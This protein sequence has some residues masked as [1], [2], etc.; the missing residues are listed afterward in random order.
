MKLP[1]HNAAPQRTLR[2]PQSTPVPQLGSSSISALYRAAR[3]GGDFY[4]FLVTDSRRLVFLLLDVAGK[5]EEALDIAA[6]VQ[7]RMHPMA[8]ELLRADDVNEADALP[9]LLIELNRVIIQAAGGVRCAPAFLGCYEE[10]FGTLTYINAGHTPALLKDNEGVTRLEANGFPLGLFSH[11]TH[12]ALITAIEPGAGLLLV[13]RG[14]VESKAGSKEYG[15]ERLTECVSKTSFQNAHDLCTQVLG[16][17]KTFTESSWRHK[18][19]ENDVTTL[20][21]VR[22]ARAAAACGG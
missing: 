18:E 16:A 22:A 15:I 6:A 4:D 13:S 21:L 14:L 10:E 5:R 8:A 1:F 20:A 3:V 19:T 11:A 2:R 9:T 17:V 12:D 7:E